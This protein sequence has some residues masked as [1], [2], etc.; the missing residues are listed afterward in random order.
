MQFVKPIP[1]KCTGCRLCEIACVNYH[2]DNLLDFQPA[3]KVF[4]HE[5]GLS[6]M[7]LVCSQCAEEFCVNVC[8][9]NSL[10]RISGS[11]IVMWTKETCIFCKQCVMACE[12]ESIHFSLKDN[13]IIKCDTCL[14]EFRC[15]RICPNNALEIG[16]MVL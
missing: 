10:L 11:G 16:E 9:T 2:Q 3:I 13:K 7:P 5:N 12:Y 8:P 1:Q 4:R 14:G 6:F 15:V